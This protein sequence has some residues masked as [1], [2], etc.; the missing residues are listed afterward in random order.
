MARLPVDF[1]Q[2]QESFKLSPKLYQI[3]H[4]EVHNNQSHRDLSPSAHSLWGQSGITCYKAYGIPHGRQ[5][6]MEHKRAENEGGFRG[7]FPGC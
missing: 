2:E 3:Q 6:H 7:A 4:I 5:L 1:P